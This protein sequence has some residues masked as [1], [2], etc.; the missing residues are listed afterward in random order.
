MGATSRWA[1]TTGTRSRQPST[2]CVN[3]ARRQTPH[4][5]V[6][7][8]NLVRLAQHQI[9]ASHP[10]RSRS[11][12]RLRCEVCT[13]QRPTGPV[14]RMPAHGGAR[15]HAN[16][17]NLIRRALGEL[18]GV[19]CFNN[20]TGQAFVAQGKLRCQTC[21]GASSTRPIRYGLGGGGGSDLVAICAPHGRAVFLEVKTGSG[22]LQENQKV[23]KQLVER[24]GAV[25][26]TV[27]SVEEALEAVKG[28]MDGD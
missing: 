13:T 28:V 17:K 26:A 2:P 18:P 10:R 14:Y 9:Q 7:P 1:P 6:Q 27:R 22:R 11:Q 16:L 8:W 21:G 20:E 12:D 5:A 19:V 4:S 15:R 23:F 24:F 25:F 3:Y